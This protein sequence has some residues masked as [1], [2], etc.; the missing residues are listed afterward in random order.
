MWADNEGKTTND[1]PTWT[2][3]RDYLS[4]QRI[5]GIPIC[6]DGGSYKINRVGERPTCS[7]GDANH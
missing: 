1:I 4:D 5:N 6:P 2:D 7:I 3:L